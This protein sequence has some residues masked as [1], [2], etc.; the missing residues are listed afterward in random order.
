MRGLG[1]DDR[2]ATGWVGILG[3]Q[4]TQSPQATACVVAAGSSLSWEHPGWLLSV[5][6]WKS[7]AQWKTKT[8][9]IRVP[10]VALLVG[11]WEEWEES[12]G[13]LVKPPEARPVRVEEPVSVWLFLGSE[14]EQRPY[15]EN[16]PSL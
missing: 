1:N 12:V 13:A 3:L 2:N 14:N 7:A 5:F 16:P 10:E 4:S 6:P 15:Y 11:E 9:C 8:V